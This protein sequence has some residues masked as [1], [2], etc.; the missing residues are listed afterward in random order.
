VEWC[1]AR[2]DEWEPL[3]QA[4]VRLDREGAR[5]RARAL[6]AEGVDERRP[7]WGIPVGIKDIV[8]VAGW[9]TTAGFAPWSDRVARTD[10]PLVTR[11]RAAGA[12]VLGKT[13]TTTFACFDPPPTR[14]PWDL[15][16][17]PGGSSSGSAAALACG[18]A[19][20]AVGSQTGGSITRPASFCGVAGIKPTYGRLPDEGIIPLARSLDHPGFLART[21]ADLSLVWSAVA[22]ED[23]R[24]DL[25]RAPEFPRVGRLGELF[26]ERAD[27]C[28]TD[29]MDRACET[30]CAAGFP[31]QNVTSPSSLRSVLANHARVI[32][33]EAA[34]WHEPLFAQ[35]RES[36]P[37]RI[38][39]LVEEGL[40][41]PAPEYIRARWHQEQ[42]KRD[43][44]E[45]F[46]DSDVLAAPAALGPAPDTSTT[47]DPAFNSP[48]SYT[49][50]PVV[51]FPIGLSPEGLP[52][53]IQLIGRPF[54][55][56]ALL[57]IAAMCEK[58]IYEQRM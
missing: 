32:A 22:G 45:C 33:A 55:E 31:T 27:P 21:A 56:R 14:N 41:L 29:A 25:A 10:A 12:V 43:V 50:L 53:A 9:P 13:V 47:G 16:R 30:F 42:L 19:L 2:T 7:L 11:L 8:D 37:P 17:T 26:A 54:A 18:M 1:L 49:G 23:A 24:D 40:A 36:Y 38:R 48:W 52:L 58:A 4:W 57:A 3:V 28:M 6:D 15:D 39:G 44:L 34:A 46:D 35:H 20:A 5:A 51:S